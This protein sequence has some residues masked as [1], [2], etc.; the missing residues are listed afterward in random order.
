MSSPYESWLEG[1]TPKMNDFY[2]DE[3][4]ADVQAAYAAG[5]KGVTGPP[6]AEQQQLAE[7]YH[8]LVTRLGNLLT[9][10]ANALKGDPDEL[11][12]HDWSDLP[13]VATAVMTDL[14]EARELADTLAVENDRL[15]QERV[16]LEARLFEARRLIKSIRT[17]VEHARKISASPTMTFYVADLERLLGLDVPR[18]HKLGDRDVD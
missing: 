6:E 14:G 11:A 7:E 12:W 5:E 10:V 18:P 8:Q 16:S 3:P 9:G 17:M 1:K 2:E 13:A 4:V 15:T